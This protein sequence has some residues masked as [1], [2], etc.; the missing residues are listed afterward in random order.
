DCHAAPNPRNRVDNGASTAA[1]GA[2]SAAAAGRLRVRSASRPLHSQSLS[3]VE[4]PS[5]SLSPSSQGDK[6]SLQLRGDIILEHLQT[7][8]I[9]LTAWNAA[10]YCEELLWP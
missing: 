8:A 9:R 4:T 1:P 5:D 3:P 2:H 6:V 10:C 7:S